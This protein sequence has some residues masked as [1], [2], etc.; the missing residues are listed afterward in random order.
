MLSALCTAF[1]LPSKTWW[2]SKAKLRWAA[3]L[4]GGTALRRTLHVQADGAG[5]INLGKTHTVEFAYG[6]WARTNV[7]DAVDPWDGGTHRAP[8]GSSSGSGVTVAARMAPWAIGIDT[9]GSVRIPVAWNGITGL[10]T[11]IGRISTFGILALGPTLDTPGPITR[12]IEDAALLLSV[13]QGEDH[14]GP[15]TLGV[16]DVDPMSELRRGVKR[17]RLARL[18]VH[19]RDGSMPRCWRHTTARLM[20][21]P[22]WG[23]NWSKSRPLLASPNWV[24]SM[25]ASCRPKLM[26]C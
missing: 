8:G 11:P 2:K 4:L 16:H 13:L 22:N 10:K 12:D 5:M 18:P 25:G 21:L 26:P 17:L 9:G 1:R 14:C 15:H 19:E 6:G 24:R 7:W 23:W 3:R 20:H